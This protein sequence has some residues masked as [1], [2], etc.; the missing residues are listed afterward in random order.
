M[1][2][3]ISNFLSFEILFHCQVDLDDF[4][5]VLRVVDLG[6]ELG[7]DDLVAVFED[8]VL[9]KVERLLDFLVVELGFCA[10]RGLHNGKV[11]LIITNSKMRIQLWW[12]EQ[13][14]YECEVMDSI[15]FL[16]ARKASGGI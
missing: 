11:V 12:K 14:L 4:L 8:F 6:R 13:F 1:I 9:E 2:P 7:F 16:V 15:T 3:R 5:R 10:K